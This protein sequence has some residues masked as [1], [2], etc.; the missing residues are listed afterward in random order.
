MPRKRFSLLNSLLRGAGFAV[1]LLQLGFLSAAQQAGG[2]SAS[3]PQVHLARVLV[4]AKGEQRNG[5]F[6]MTEP[7]SVFYVPDDREVIVYFEWEG[8]K[9]SH[10]CEGS[11]RGPGGQFATM[12]S[13]DY[14]ATQARFVGFWRVPLAESSPPEAGCLKAGWMARLRAKCRSR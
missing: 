7:R 4:G 3:G 13:F 6:V 2:V 5:A 12:S 8:A 1:A 14:V 9:G 11:V 10:H